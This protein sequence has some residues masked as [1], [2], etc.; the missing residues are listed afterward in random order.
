MPKDENAVSYIEEFNRSHRRIKREEKDWYV[1]YLPRGLGMEDITEKED[2][3]LMVIFT[4]AEE[5]MEREFDIMVRDRFIGYF[6]SLAMVDIQEFLPQKPSS[7]LL[8]NMK[9]EDRN[10]IKDIYTEA[11]EAGYIKKTIRK[12]IRKYLDDHGYLTRVEIEEGLEPEPEV[13]KSRKRVEK[14]YLKKKE[15][16]LADIE[17][18]LPQKPSQIR[19]GDLDDEDRDAIIKICRTGM[20]SGYVKKTIR[21]QVRRI[22]DEKNYFD[23]IRGKGKGEKAGE[24]AGEKGR[25]IEAK[26]VEKKTGTKAPAVKKIKRKGEKP[27][28]ME[29]E[30]TPSKKPVTKMDVKRAKKIEVP[31]PDALLEFLPQKPVPVLLSSLKIKDREQIIEIYRE[32]MDAKL[33]KRTIRKRIR[34]YLN[35]HTNYEQES[36][37]TGKNGPVKQTKKK[38]PKKADMTT[39][40]KAS[41]KGKAGETITEKMVTGKATK[42][43]SE[44]RTGTGKDKN[45]QSSAVS[46][47]VSQSK[48]MTA[49][50]TASEKNTSDAKEKRKMAEKGKMAGK[51]KKN[52]PGV[53]KA[54]D[55]QG[56]SKAKRST[57]SSKKK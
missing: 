12:Q 57:G 16:E 22:L 3:E 34:R 29:G 7:V 51:G 23:R 48:G 42:A 19:L 44:K 21:K 46:K 54:P 8:E 28:N 5:E 1:M 52:V 50:K 24:K 40:S 36:R 6:E 30:A 45:D 2:R 33:V 41:Q 27:E 14:R 13:K 25:P 38:E 18:F 32:G 31:D 9:R 53:G 10:A 15:M 47:K 11:I 56:E 35:E 4:R 43:R 17:G 37:K 26:T 55:E 39:S 49:K 20:E